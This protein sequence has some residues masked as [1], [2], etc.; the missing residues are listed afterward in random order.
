MRGIYTVGRKGGTAV[1]ASYTAPGRN[2]VREKVEFVPEGQ[3]FA[4]R[5]RAAK[6]RARNVLTKRR[7]AVLEDRFDL[8]RS[9][10]VYTFARFVREVYQAE[11][12]HRGLRGLQGEIRRLTSGPLGQ[13]F[14]VMVL[15]DLSDWQV[16]RY[17]K[18][19]RE[20]R[21]GQGPVGPAAINRDLARL[22]NLWNVAKRKGVVSGDNPV[23]TAGRLDEPGGRVRYLTPDDERRLLEACSPALRAIVE[24]A[25]HTGIRKGAI[26]G[27]RWQDVDLAAGLITVP[28]VLSKSKGAYHVAINR[29]VAELLA[30]RR[31]SGFNS[32]EDVVFCT[33]RGE[34]RRSIENAWKRARADAGLEDFRFH[35]LRHTSASRIVQAGHSLFDAGEH[36]GHKT[37]SMTKRY[38]HLSPERLHRI[39]AATLPEPAAEVVPIS[40]RSA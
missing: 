19:R 36:L 8:P 14:G 29:R 22:S 16:Q 37:A 11:L 4:S 35:D 7:A 18:A 12:E 24:F 34:R 26:L 3:G 40:P 15:R 5:L 30:E 31:D 10:R 23:R 6:V 13:F 17:V 32:P 1:Y 9:H 39:A 38:A 28:A 33:R 2:Q 21:V 20:G 27:L 25:L